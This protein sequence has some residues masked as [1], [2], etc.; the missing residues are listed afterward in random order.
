MKRLAVIGAGISGLA[1]AY[2]LRDAPVAVTVFE[3]SRGVSGRAA[4]RRK[5]GFLYDHGANY[6]RPDTDRVRQLIAHELP[7]EDLVDIGRPVWVFDGAGTIREGD[8]AA[9]A[10][11][12]WTYRS[13]IS[14]L[15][16]LL[17]RAA[18]VDV[19]TQVRVVRL[20]HNGRTWTVVDADGV[21]YHPFDAVLL[22]PPAPQTREIL[23]AGWFDAGVQEAVVDG[24]AIA[25]YSSQFAVM[26]AYD[27]VLP[28]PG[29]FY[30]LVNTDGEHAVG[31][32]SFEDDKPGH[33]PPG[34]S[35]LVVQMAPGWT[36]AHY[37]A[38][39]ATLA[40][41]A[42]RAAGALL[43]VP[44]PEPIWTDRQRWR[45]ALPTAPADVER[46]RAAEAIGLFF[47]G[48]ALVGRGRVARALETG[49]EAAAALRS[50]LR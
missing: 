38:S 8:P 32:L 15:G 41:A 11:P 46:L 16:K 49:L 27:A 12:K 43:A 34:H 35:L 45:Y 3:K 9:N 2:A 13:G 29:P 42:H 18:D 22:T 14:T 4:T 21:R 44:L 20:E 47:A 30:G 37:D 31:W 23:A 19:H 17:A 33:V 39:P 5:Q 26:L 10:A 50:F 7:T 25:S 40:E 48:D 36:L 1:A 28:R 6:I 24:L